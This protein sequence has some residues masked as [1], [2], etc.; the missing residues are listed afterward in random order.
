MISSELS[1]V[2][3]PLIQSDVATVRVGA[4]AEVFLHALRKTVD[5][6]IVG[7]SP[8]PVMVNGV[9]SYTVT[10]V[11]PRVPRSAKPGMTADVRIVTAERRN[12]L[13]LP[14][15]AVPTNGRTATVRVLRDGRSRPVRVRIGVRGDDSVEVLSG[16][17]PGERVA[18][19]GGDQSGSGSGWDESG[20]GGFGEDESGSG[21]FG[22]DES[23]S[24][25]G[26]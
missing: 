15:T 16:V 1:L 3:A 23:G 18:V 2:S 13:S 14:A 20:S 10:V 17:R 11:A 21:G 5:A 25:F 9:V 4:R 6:S 22:E 7:I 8:E 12:V 19:S 26:G 24:G